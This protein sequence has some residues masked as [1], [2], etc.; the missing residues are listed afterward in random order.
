MHS[1]SDTALLMTLT[2]FI[3]QRLADQGIEFT[4]MSEAMAGQLF[5]SIVGSVSLDEYAVL[6]SVTLL[7]HLLQ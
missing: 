2:L 3:V 7:N 1:I 6:A 5:E 4:R